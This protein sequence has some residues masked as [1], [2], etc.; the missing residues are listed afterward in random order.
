MLHYGT[1]VL[2]ANLLLLYEGFPS[3]IFTEITHE[4]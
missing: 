1:F 4:Y 2:L 3:K